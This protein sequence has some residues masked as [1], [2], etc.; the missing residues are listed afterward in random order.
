M[1]DFNILHSFYTTF[2]VILSC[3]CFS[4]SFY[5]FERQTQRD[6][7]RERGRERES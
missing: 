1:S 5:L 6:G 2:Y 3:I 4:K 7:G